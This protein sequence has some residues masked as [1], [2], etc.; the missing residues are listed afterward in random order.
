MF[1][2]VVPTKVESEKLL[3]YLYTLMMVPLG[4]LLVPLIEVASDCNP[5][6][7]TGAM[8]FIFQPLASKFSSKSANVTAGKIVISSDI[9]WS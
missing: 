5:E 9:I 2:V 8:V 6:F 7:T 3:V 4:S 1:T